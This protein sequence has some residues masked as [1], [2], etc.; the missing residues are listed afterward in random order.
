M[1]V[2]PTDQTAPAE[3][4]L[5]RAFVNTRDVEEGTD[6]LQ[7]PAEAIAWL[8]AHALGG[9]ER[10]LAEP[11]RDRLVE[12]R[13]ALRELL[14]ANNLSEPPPAAALAALN[15]QSAEAAVTLRF[16][17]EGAALVTSCGGVDS[18]I[19]RLLAIVHSAMGDGTWRRL[20]ACPA[21]DC[22]WAFYDHSRNRS[23]TWCEMGECGNREKARRFRE[24]HRGT[25]EPIA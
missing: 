7:S 12:V 1:T 15:E 21:A 17:A 8:S 3:L 24:R 9:G 14:L 11:D 23:G 19:A 25:D 6:A 2:M 13:E 4:E 5:V 18:A 16:D 10:S 22:R 20:K